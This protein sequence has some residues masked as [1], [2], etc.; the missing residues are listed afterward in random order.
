MDRERFEALLKRCCTGGASVD[1]SAVFVEVSSRYREPHRRYHSPQHIRH[2]L[3]EF[4][5]AAG[6]LEDRDAVEMALWFHDVV[7][8]AR[9]V[10]SSNERRSAELFEDRLG[11]AVTP[12]FRDTV[13]RLVMVTV[14]P[15]EPST[16]DEGYLVDIDL[17][18]FGLSWEEFR[19]D[20]QA[21]RD[22]VPHLTDEEFF[23]KQHRFLRML[24]G[25]ENFFVTDFFAARYEKVARDNIERLLRETGV[26]EA[27]RS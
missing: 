15:S 22:E 23:P 24:L 2:C 6:H 16:A 21:V 1:P 11:E 20:S 19:R 27:R 13:Y 8:E 9:A 17:S 26:R 4:D 5:L 18:S 14:Y 3:R 25:R 10:P 7:W 12:E